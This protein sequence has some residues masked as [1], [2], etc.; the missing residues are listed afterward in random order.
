[1]PGRETGMMISME[2]PL[3]ILYATDLHGEKWKYDALL[4]HAKRNGFH[5]IVNGGDMLPHLQGTDTQGRFIREFLD[6][7]FARCGQARIRNLFIPGNDDLR[8]HD[9]TL[10]ALCEKHSCAENIAGRKAILGTHEIVGFNLVADYPF[11]LKDRC[12]MDTNEFV[13]P[14]QRGTGLLSRNGGY[15]EITDWPTYAK[16]L[17]TIECEMATLPQTGNPATTVYVIHMPP[18]GL[19]LDVCYGNRPVGSRAV[20]AFLGKRSPLLSLHGHIHESPEVTGAWQAKIGKTTCVQP[21]QK[22]GRLIAVEVGL[23]PLTLKR[24]DLR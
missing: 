1:M 12:R 6:D 19:G 10:A 15:D 20:A 4:D 17:P 11:R 18:S 14:H 23:D 9:V 2:P 13:F 24:V 8:I 5:A 7:H 16:T 21:G 3:K 22:S